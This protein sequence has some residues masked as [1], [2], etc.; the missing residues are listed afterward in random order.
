MKQTTKFR[1]WFEVEVTDD[2]DLFTGALD[3]VEAKGMGPLARVRYLM[4]PNGTYPH[5]EICIG[6]MLEHQIN[7]AGCDCSPLNIVHE[8]GEKP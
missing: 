1:V 6:A 4:D 7:L 3:A 2:H 5:R 8:K